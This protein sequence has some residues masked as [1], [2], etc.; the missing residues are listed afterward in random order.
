MTVAFAFQSAVTCL[1]WPPEQP[2]IIFGLA[3]GKVGMAKQN[4][5]FAVRVDAQSGDGIRSVRNLP[6]QCEQKKYRDEIAI[7]SLTESE[8]QRSECFLFL[9]I[10]LLIPLLVI[11]CELVDLRI[12][13]QA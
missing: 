11:K 12:E 3:D 2:N 13:V 9:L 8:S 7:I 1:I 6:F 4:V 10:P 5:L